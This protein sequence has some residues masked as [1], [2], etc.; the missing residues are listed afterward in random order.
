MSHA[1]KCFQDATEWFNKKREHQST[2]EH[3]EAELEALRLEWVRTSRDR[4]QKIALLKTR[5]RECYLNKKRIEENNRAIASWEVLTAS[6]DYM[7][8]K[9]EYASNCLHFLRARVD[10]Y[11]LTVCGV[12]DSLS[13]D[14]QKLSEQLS[15][16]K[17]NNQLTTLTVYALKR[18][19]HSLDTIIGLAHVQIICE[20]PVDE[21]DFEVCNYGTDDEYYGVMWVPQKLWKNKQFG[22]NSHLGEWV[23][24]IKEDEPAKMLFGGYGHCEI[25][26]SENI[27]VD[28]RYFD[29]RFD[30]TIDT[31]LDS[32]CWDY[33]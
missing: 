6:E 28:C 17:L 33:N 14:I 18:A 24:L 30:F 15:K 29:N 32:I 9:M 21:L 5:H 27:T 26:S 11:D 1:Y 4:R 7:C 3:E 23:R 31:T 2:I 16:L 8:R 19:G 12:G 22:E 20:I 10:K 25:E 13:D